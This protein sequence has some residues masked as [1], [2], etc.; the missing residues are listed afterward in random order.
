VASP[1]PAGRGPS[2]AAGASRRT[3]DPT[4]PDRSSARQGAG[5][6]AAPSGGGRSGARPH[7]RSRALAASTIR[8]RWSSRDRVVGEAE[9]SAIAR[10]AEALLERRDEAAVAERRHVAADAH[11]DVHRV[12]RRER[13]PA[14]MRIPPFRPRLAASARASSVPARGRLQFESELPR[15]RRH[16]L[17]DHAPMCQMRSRAI[18][19]FGTTPSRSTFA[20]ANSEATVDGTRVPRCPTNRSERRPFGAT[21]SASAPRSAPPPPGTARAPAAPRRTTCAAIA[22]GSAGTGRR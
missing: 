7:A 3:N 19:I 14:L 11:G 4:R 5:A 12:A 9:S 22:A 20:A 8:C 13:R 1:P 2:R 21:R 10:R 16:D 17:N 6:V 18:L 15:S